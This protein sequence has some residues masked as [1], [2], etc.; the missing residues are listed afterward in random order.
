MFFAACCFACLDWI[1]QYFNH[2]AFCYVAIYGH[3]F[4]QSAKATWRLFKSSGFEAIA[5]DWLLD[6]ILWMGTLLGAI[7]GATVGILLSLA[8][9]LGGELWP[10]LLIGLGAP[11]LFPISPFSH[12]LSYGLRT[13]SP[14]ATAD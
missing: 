5:N 14:S 7:I 11:A 3:T 9:P 2:Y 4:I 13:D 10:G 12:C 1:V 8:F 6:G